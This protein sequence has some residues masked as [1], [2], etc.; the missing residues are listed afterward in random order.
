M[1]RQET[2]RLKLRWASRRA[3]ASGSVAPCERRLFNDRH[4]VFFASIANNFSML[5]PTCEPFAPNIEPT[6]RLLKRSIANS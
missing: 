1:A 4:F 5:T 6:M 2:Q 3:M